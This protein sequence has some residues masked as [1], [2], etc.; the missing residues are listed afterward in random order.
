MSGWLQEYSYKCQ[1]VD[2]SHNPTALRVGFSTTANIMTNV[3]AT[4]SFKFVC[5]FTNSVHTSQK[6]LCISITNTNQYKIMLVLWRQWGRVE[7]LLHSFLTSAI[8]GSKLS[9]SCPSHSTLREKARN[10]HLVGDWT[11]CRPSCRLQAFEPQN[12]RACS[13]V[14][15]LTTSPRLKLQD[16]RIYISAFVL[17]LTDGQPVLV[18]LLIKIHRIHG[19]SEY[20]NKI[21]NVSSMK[22]VFFPTAQ[23]S[24]TK[25]HSLCILTHMHGAKSCSSNVPA[26]W[27]HSHAVQYLI[28][29]LN[30]SFL[31]QESPTQTIPGSNTWFWKTTQPHITLTKKEVTI[32]VETEHTIWHTPYCL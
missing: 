25:C 18:V 3:R 32:F 4:W 12:V 13:P 16:I 5:I 27:H 22:H 15:I 21:C 31:M 7:V 29:Q 20:W 23:H 17:F 30:S 28:T 2:Y 19:H 24:S 14:A 8:D 9:V 26:L 1:P 10:I 6:T 11:F